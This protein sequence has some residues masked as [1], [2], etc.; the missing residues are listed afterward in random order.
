M[1][2]DAIC[3]FCNRAVKD[4]DYDDHLVSCSDRTHNDDKVCN[5]LQRCANNL[6]ASGYSGLA[7][8]LGYM[9]SSS[10]NEL[11]A[12]ELN[13]SEITQAMAEAAL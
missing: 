8:I 4:A 3:P 10:P 13:S 2:P 5:M 1:I 12:L 9:A 6:E 11:E 7:N